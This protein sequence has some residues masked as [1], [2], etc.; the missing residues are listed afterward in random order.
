MGMFGVMDAPCFQ[1]TPFYDSG[2]EYIESPCRRL[3]PMCEGVFRVGQ[4]LRRTQESSE[5][6]GVSDAR[7]V[8]VSTMAASPSWPWDGEFAVGGCLGTRG[9]TESA[10][11]LFNAFSFSQRDHFTVKFDGGVGGGFVLFP[12]LIG[13][14]VP[15]YASHMESANLLE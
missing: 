6:A 2:F 15:R 11:H 9:R 1:T 4:R 10:A 7:V 5:W 14:T 13:G 8:G 12:P 3:P